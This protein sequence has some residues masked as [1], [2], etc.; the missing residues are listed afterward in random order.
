MG[1]YKRLIL[2]EKKPKQ[3]FF[4]WGARQ[5]GKSTLLSTQFPEA[6][7]ID[8]LHS[9]IFAKYV[10]QPHLIREELAHL[11]PG[12]L[13][14]I[15]EIQKVP[16]LLD[17]VHGLIESRK[18]NFALSGSS[19][20]KLRRNHANL[21]GGRAIR[22]ELFGLSAAELGADFDLTRML[23][24]G[25]LPSHYTCDPADWKRVAL[26]Y[27]GDYLR[28]DV[29]AESLSRGLTGFSTFL[30]AAAISDTEILTSSRHL[31]IPYVMF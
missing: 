12:S 6:T 14:V 8:L 25:Y 18:L 13:V 5:T 20:R 27:A 16:A 30:H 23:N 28:E 1:M 22:R 21:L 4:L 11:E 31:N 2:L 9:D 15:D 10:T 29:A 19:A 7:Y 24:Q 17:E 3:S 26:S